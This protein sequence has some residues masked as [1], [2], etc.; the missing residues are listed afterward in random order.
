MSKLGV[1]SDTHLRSPDA[2]LERILQES[3]ADVDMILHLGDYVDYSIAGYLMEHKKFIGVTGNMDPPE[4]RE[5]FPPK[6]IVEIAN[7]RIGIIHGWGAPFGLERKIRREFDDVDAIVYGHI[8]RPINHRR[9]G[10]LYFNPGSPSRSLFGQGT[11]GILSVTE[12]IQ[13]QIIPL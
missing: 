6:R 2:S 12:H 7:F 9:G 4:I 8:H 5:R 11:V 1:I 3:F 10:I 13:G